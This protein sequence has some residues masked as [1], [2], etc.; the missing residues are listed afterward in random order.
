MVYQDLRPGC[1][2]LLPSSPYISGPKRG[3]LAES[4]SEPH[5]TRPEWASQEVFTMLR[6]P[7]MYVVFIFTPGETI[8]MWLSPCYTVLAC[9]RVFSSEDT[10][11]SC[12]SIMILLSLCVLGW[13]GGGG[14]HSG[15]LTMGGC[16]LVFCERM[17]SGTTYITIFIIMFILK[18][19][20]VFPGPF[21][22]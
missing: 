10:C 5:E 2:K 20:A 3:S 9:G 12:P 14:I 15:V 8:A 17:K 21:L 16:L 13:R 22:I 6:E 11:S 18:T 1:C 4:H 19:E 7:D